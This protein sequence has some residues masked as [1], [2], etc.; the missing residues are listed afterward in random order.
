MIDTRTYCEMVTTLNLVGTAFIA[1]NCFLLI[2][3]LRLSEQLSNIRYRIVNH[4]HHLCYNRK[5]VPFGHLH[6]VHLTPNPD[7]DNHRS[8]LC[9]SEFGFLRFHLDVRS[10]RPFSKLLKTFV[11]LMINEFE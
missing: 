6:P 4:C 8:V 3:L 10:Q 5:S 9:I 11:I 2:K 7:S 1:T